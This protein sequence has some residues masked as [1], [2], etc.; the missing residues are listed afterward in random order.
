MCR[1]RRGGPS[2]DELRN[3]STLRGLQPNEMG[4]KRGKLDKHWLL[5]AAAASWAECLR[6]SSP[7]PLPWATHVEFL[8]LV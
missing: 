5:E 2:I 1:H 4:G 3:Y 8:D 7:S 6:Q